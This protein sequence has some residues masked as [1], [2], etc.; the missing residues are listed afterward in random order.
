MDGNITTVTVAVDERVFGPASL[1]RAHTATS[2]HLLHSTRRVVVFLCQ[3]QLAGYHLPPHKDQ[4]KGGRAFVL[5]IAIL[6]ES[7]ILGPISTKSH[8]SVALVLKAVFFGLNTQTQ[9]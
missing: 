5:R 2:D 7:R 8:I 1:I 4:E 6:P 9:Y 3:I